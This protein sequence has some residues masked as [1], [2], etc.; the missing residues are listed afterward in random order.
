MRIRN[1]IHPPRML[2][3]RQRLSKTERAAHTCRQPLNAALT[4][5]AG[6]QCA[7][8]PFPFSPAKPLMSQTLSTRIRELDPVVI[9][10]IAAG[11]VI[12]RP[13]SVVK[14]LLENSLDALA[15]RIDVEIVDG[16]AELIRVVDDGEGIH[17]DDLMLAVTSHATSKIESSDDLFSVQTMGF[18]GEALASIASVSR[19]RLRTRQAGSEAGTEL[20]V[21][22]GK[23]GRPRPCGCPTGTQIEV[24]QLFLNTPVRRKFLKT[25]STE[26]AHISEQFTRIALAN[27]RLQMSLKHN[28]K[29]VYQ[30]PPSEN[31]LERLRMFY[32]NEVA[33][34]LIWVES[35]VPV[36]LDDETDR[37]QVVRV[38]GYVAHPSHSKASRKGQYLFLNGRWIQDR[39]L[40][41]ALG[42]AYR[43]LLMVGRHPV[44]FLFLEMPAS[45]V[46]V[47]VHPCKWEVRFR[48]GQ[49][50]Y[51]QLLS[52][53]RSRF[54][55]MDLDSQ[56][57]LG[58]P[59]AAAQSASSVPATDSN[60]RLAASAARQLTLEDTRIP[61][62]PSLPIARTEATGSD[63]EWDQL[64][65][66]REH[67]ERVESTDPRS[68]S[69]GLTPGDPE[70][71]SGPGAGPGFTATAAADHSAG[72]A[73]GPSSGPA[74]SPYSGAHRAIQ[75]HDCYLVLGTERGLMVIDQHA[76]HERIMY[77]Y[78]KRRMTEGSIERQRLLVPATI[79]MSAREA[80]VFVEH[81]D[82]L[83]DLGFEVE[84]FGGNTILLSSYPAIF[85]RADHVQL[86]VDL[87]E[88]LQ[89][90][91]KKLDTR[92]VLDELLQ[93]MSCKAAIKA[94]QRLSPEEMD[95]L[96]EQRHLV[97]DTHHCP[98]G[99]PTA[100]VLSR[101]ELDRQFG[102]LG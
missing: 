49:Q 10:R 34:K 92:D 14:E 77:E 86:L 38:W 101:D 81:Q 63:R 18:R 39:S 20:E 40:Q 79:E 7:L 50:L 22:S 51:R 96:L 36:Q 70:T 97:D 28:D 54:L 99:R 31:M 41:H 30:L 25:R 67:H 42:E 2:R 19:F 83:R 88:R 58:R 82:L 93:M 72:V 53:L 52:C 16:G 87:G 56:M 26:F 75:V 29:S 4:E 43:G 74:A 71:E 90:P 17:P 55:S 66:R 15:T 68:T 21:D 65:K 73:S 24:R 98:H 102:R 11:E 94:G 80:A 32:G 64:L 78:L 5:S 3:I 35:E 69:P 9:N 60:E 23:P 95:A 13:A 1:R 62:T 76:L 59:P 84:E 45:L 37:P 33:E 44:A 6:S 57:K 100:L 48:D 91:G 8:H 47:N 89:Q 12:E 61:W 46:D 27:P 85:R